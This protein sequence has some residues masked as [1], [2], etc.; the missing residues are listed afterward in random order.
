[1]GVVER[2]HRIFIGRLE[3]QVDFPIGSYARTI[4]TISDPEIRLAVPPVADGPA[5]IHLPREAEHPQDLS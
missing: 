5:E 3:G 4:R 1:M 2:A